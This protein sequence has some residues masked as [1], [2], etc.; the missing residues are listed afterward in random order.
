MVD[1]KE[2]LKIMEN[3]NTKES[4]GKVVKWTKKSL[5]LLEKETRI[6]FF[7]SASDWLKNIF[8]LNNSSEKKSHNESAINQAKNNNSENPGN[9]LDAYT[10]EHINKSVVKK[11]RNYI[12]DLQAVTH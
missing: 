10:N 9:N 1:V 11:A 6:N 3:V 7:K 5:S 8:W 12:S 4:E 2:M